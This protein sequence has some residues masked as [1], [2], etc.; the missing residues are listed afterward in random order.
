MTETHPESSDEVRLPQLMKPPNID[1]SAMEQ[2]LIQSVRPGFDAIIIEKEFLGGYSGT[3][4]FLVLPIWPNGARAA[5]IVTKIGPAMELSSERDKYQ[6]IVA[7]DLPFT[8]TQVRDYFEKDGQAALNY[9][10]VGGDALGKVVSLEEYYLA[11]SA[12]AV[13]STLQGLLDR[14][15]SE[16]WYRQSQPLNRPFRDEYGRHLPSHEKLE[17]I[18]AAIFPRLSRLPDERVGIPGV[19]GTFPHPLTVYPQINDRTLEGYQYYVHGDL[20]LRNVLV[21]QTGKGWLIDFAKVGQRHNLFDF[22]KLETYIRLMVLPAVQGGFSWEEYVRFEDYLLN[23]ARVPPANKD[24]QSACQVIRS[25][26]EIARHCARDPR[27]FENEYLPGLF[28]YCLAMM[29]YCESNGVPPTQL[30]FLTACVLARH[31]RGSDG[32]P[33]GCRRLRDRIREWLWRRR[34][35]IAA[36]S[37]VLLTAIGVLYAIAHLPIPSPPV[38][39]L[40]FTPT[41]T[42]TPT[43]TATRTATWTP[44]PTSTPT[45]TDMPGPIPPGPAA[46]MPLIVIV[47]LEDR[48]HGQYQGANPAQ[49]VY[50][51]IFAQAQRDQIDLR[52]ERLEQMPDQTALNTMGETNQ[53]I[54]ILSGWHD[55]AEITFQLE[56]FVVLSPSGAVKKTDEFS[57]SV[58][59]PSRVRFLILFVLGVERYIDGYHDKA[60]SYLDSALAIVS[61][62]GTAVNPGE[63]YFLRGLIYHAR[64][65]RRRA[66]AEYTQAAEF[67]RDF[68]EVYNSR[69]A[70]YDEIGEYENALADYDTAIQMLPGS[71]TYYKN[72]G[73]TYAHMSEYDKAI[74]DY[75]QAIRL[76]PDDAEAYYD[77]GNAYSDTGRHVLAIADYTQ[78]IQ[79]DPGYV[80]AYINRGVTYYSLDEIDH[81]IADYD[82]AIKLDPYS[83]DGYNNRGEAYRR[84]GLYDL[85]IADL[86]RA[87]ALDPGDFV[88]YFNRGLTYENKEEPAKAIADYRRV[89]ELN[90]SPD[91]RQRAEQRL[92][93][94]GAR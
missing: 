49:S 77:R 24:L 84:K 71:V 85:A 79:I 25:I 50:D 35:S 67:M 31:L 87:I 12:E 48:S 30:M 38:L 69:G 72:R 39:T 68:A 64:G 63:A 44:S 7:Q 73:N 6:S 17:R 92:K 14:A 29:K 4:V 58:E 54:F 19:E 26:R 81:A 65:D 32:P 91:V 57:G 90:P 94:L 21:D 52:I 53:P 11:N 42:P 33:D 13:V 28:L 41:A 76:K 59:L 37:I 45:P 80:D 61:A 16:N 88:A 74:A 3:R 20:H 9:V 15:L 10:F 22:I 75:T 36:I 27:N 89:L 47:N 82:R 8:A 93:D 43:P 78:A 70:A 23:P 56:L 83:Q 5:R 1:L 60:L 55:A 34:R 46:N 2:L 86:D 66:I 51:E 62:G 18:T 40:T